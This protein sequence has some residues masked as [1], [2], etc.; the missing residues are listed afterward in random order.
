MRRLR[1]THS[2]QKSV[3]IQL[4]DVLR[5]FG[6]DVV[7][8]IPGGAIASLYAAFLG[9]SDIR[10]IT[11][12][13]ETNA[14]FLAVGY[15]MATGRPGVVLTT[16]GP[17]VTNAIT[18]IATAHYEGI[19]LVHI[20]GEVP[21]SAFG[22]GALQEGSSAGFDA[23]SLFRNITKASVQLSQPLAAAATLRNAIN[24]ALTGK[25]GPVF[26]SLPLDV[27]A[28]STTVQPIAGSVQ[29][30]F[31]I[32]PD[33]V[34]E[35]MRL[36][37]EASRPLI[38]A[39]A[40]TRDRK[41]RRAIIE[42]AEHAGSPVCV[43][44]KGKGVFPEDHPLY[45]GVLGFG[46]HESVV[47]YLRS[48]VDVGLVVG[49]GLNDFTTNGWTS[50][51]SP[52]RAFVQIDIDPAQLGK[53]YPLTLG[54]VGPADTVVGRMLEHAR[55]ARARPAEAQRIRYQE[56]K[57]S[58]LGLL[59]TAEVVS[60]M[61]DVLPADAIVTADMGEH[62]AFALHYYRAKEAGDFFTCLGFGS[63][64]SGIV[65]AIGYQLGAPGRRSYAVC[66][67]GGFLMCGSELATA[68][69]H[70]IPTTF[71]V[72]NDSRLNMVHHGLR[73]L[74]GDSPDFSTQEIDFAAMAR[75]MG[76]EGHVVRTRADLVAGLRAATELPVVLDVRVDAD[77]RL[78]GSQRVAA[79]RQF[80]EANK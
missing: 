30:R 36:L 16:S 65:S 63:M 9:R 24:V 7:F 29:T 15:A 52:S 33:G 8:G 69:Q 47:D 66:G 26:V 14:A 31:A 74:F 54:I 72:I 1:G 37:D 5:E 4:V 22:R 57:R 53:N 32:D 34:R 62:L 51:L 25:R 42:L 46:G 67:D 13:H 79:L 56:P 40:G 59:T 43:T 78:G 76:G 55:P 80:T 64:G 77:I 44:T 39:G 49:T 18:G 41:S 27:A 23:V 6:V 3:S 19:P 68:V 61:N 71:V 73:D 20:A 38:V 50:E 28:T 10:L 60:T 12:K 21:R 17:G 45:L 75:S 2:V 35:A 11:T 48:G 58:A 70:R